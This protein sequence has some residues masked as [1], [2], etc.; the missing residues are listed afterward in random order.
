V[1]AGVGWAHV[2]QHGFGALHG[3]GLIHGKIPVFR[4]PFSVFSERG[5][6]LWFG[7]CPFHQERKTPKRYL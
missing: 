2:Q 1:G 6:F 7:F 5:Y 3:S 4:F